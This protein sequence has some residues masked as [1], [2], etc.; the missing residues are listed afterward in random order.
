[1]TFFPA[2]G[3][4]L[5]VWLW[6]VMRNPVNGV[7]MVIAVV[8]FGMFAA[9]AIGGLSLVLAN[10][11]AILTIGALILQW[12]GGR[13][14]RRPLSIPAAGIFLVVFAAYSLFSAFVLVRIFQGQFL[15]FPMNVT[16]KSTLVSI[17]FPSTMVPL[18]PTKSNIAQSFYILLSSGFF[19]ATVFVLRRK[20]AR[21]AETG[22]AWAAGIN[23]TLGLLDFLGLDNLLSAV[24]TADYSLANHH[25]VAGMA[26]IIGGYSEASAFGASSAALAAYFAMAFLIGRSGR[27]GLLA[28]VNLACAVLALSS[29]AFVAIGVGGVVI[30][31]HARTFLARSLSRRAAHLFVIAIAG[32]VIGLCLLIMLTPFPALFSDLVDRLI[33]SKQDSLSGMERAAWASAGFD[34]FSRT[35]GLG[36]G[37]GSLRGSGL[38]SVLLGSVGLPGML[39]FLGFLFFAIGKTIETTNPD[40]FR[41]YYASRVCA[42]TLLASMF[43]SATVPD[44][45]LLLMAVTALAVSAR[46]MAERTE[47]PGSRT[48]IRGATVPRTSQI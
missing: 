34:A 42:L 28:L 22:L 45:T 15:V 44:P 8:P 29:T 35:W 47:N 38:A 46:E 48:D 36:A 17:F 27:D 32:I 18:R 26:R 37:A 41:T 33:F 7:P 30:V 6:S 1:M 21:F 16:Y 13:G 3:V 39:A 23:A 40:L 2:A 43:L 20:G 19:L 12:F 5:L 14:A 4:F 24:R 10:L 11:L 25:T 31:L 9:V